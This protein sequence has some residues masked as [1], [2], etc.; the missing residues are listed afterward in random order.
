MTRTREE[1]IALIK[2]SI[3]E[4][5]IADE[6]FFKVDESQ[7]IWASRGSFKAFS[8]SEIDDWYFSQGMG[9]FSKINEAIVFMRNIADEI[10]FEFKVDGQFVRI[11]KEEVIKEIEVPSNEQHRLGGMVEAYEKILIN[12]EVT[13]AK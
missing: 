6:I 9:D 11:K 12:R 13:I 3:K 10:G 7:T 1:F 8:M 4:E 5:Y 2:S